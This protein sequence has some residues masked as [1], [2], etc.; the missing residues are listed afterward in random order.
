[1]GNFS[2]TQILEKLEK[3]QQDLQISQT[4]KTQYIKTK[5][6][7]I[8]GLKAELEK[9]KEKSDKL[10]MAYKKKILQKSKIVQRIKQMALGVLDKSE[11][12]TT[13]WEN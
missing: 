3:A 10:N 7:E 13:D 1:M 11:L 8:A 9:M 4:D 12:T 6:E 5:Q 2:Y